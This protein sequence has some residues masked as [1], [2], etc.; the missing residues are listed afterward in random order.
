MLEMSKI[1]PLVVYYY[2][3]QILGVNDAEKGSAEAWKLN[4]S[5]FVTQEDFWCK[6]KRR[7]L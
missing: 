4:E 7:R 2:D 3:I 5:W 1:L 6:T